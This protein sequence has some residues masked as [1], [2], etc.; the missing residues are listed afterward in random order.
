SSGGGAGNGVEVRVLFWAPSTVRG[1]S[2]TVEKTKQN[3]YIEQ[4]AVAGVRSRSP[5]IGGS[6]G[7][8]WWP[9]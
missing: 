9:P 7:P 5:A 6:L 8:P 3:R 4:Q 1:S 2:R